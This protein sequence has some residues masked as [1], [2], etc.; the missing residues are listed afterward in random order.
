MERVFWHQDEPAIGP[1]HF[2]PWQLNRAT[3]QAGVRVVLDGFD[4][5]TTVSHGA[6]RFT[7]LARAGEWDTF[8]LEANA[9]SR[10]FPTSPLAILKT[11]GLPFLEELARGQR[12][13]AFVAAINRINGCFQVSRRD[14]LWQHGLRP[15]IPSQ[16]LGGRR[17]P[18]TSIDSIINPTFARRIGLQE[19]VRALRG[20]RSNLPRTAREDHWRTLTSGLFTSVLEISDRCAAAFSIDVRHPFMDKRLVEWCLALPAKQKLSQGW[21]RI[22]M[23]RS[24]SG[25]VP[26]EIRWRGG[27]TDMNPNFLHGLLTA[28]R[29]VLDEVVLHPSGGIAQ[30][31]DVHALGQA[32]ERLT[33][34]ERVKIDDAMA[35][36][37]V[38]TL[39]YWLRSTGL[40]TASP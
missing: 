26:E 18:V 32:Y 31:V 14:L 28:D 30:Y 20:A 34:R 16:I 1:N 19:R 11:Y 2:L 12:W 25:I 9:V 3:R 27:K 29:R 37:K 7:E 35:V 36:W 23:R 10:H 15:L 22:V 5:D 38:A 13:I 4:G 39:A 17:H 6:A 21:S 8:A 40:E 24:M 33:S